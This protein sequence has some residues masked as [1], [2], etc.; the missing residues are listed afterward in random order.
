MLYHFLLKDENLTEPSPFM[1]RPVCMSLKISLAIYTP[2]TQPVQGFIAEFFP[3]CK[4]LREQKTYNALQS[5]QKTDQIP[6]SITSSH[7]SPQVLIKYALV[8]AWVPCGAN[9]SSPPGWNIISVFL[10]Q[11]S[12]ASTGFQQQRL[13]KLLILPWIPLFWSPNY[14][15]SYSSPNN[16]LFVLP[17]STF[18]AITSPF[19]NLAKIMNIKLYRTQRSL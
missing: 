10:M 16:G 7:I 15:K 2:C 5:S 17:F 4:V 3:H 9:L 1:I 14:M 18:F 13:Q 19:F 12:N 6:G 11:R 8:R